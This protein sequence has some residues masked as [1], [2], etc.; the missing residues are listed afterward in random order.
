MKI[1]I[2][3]II[4]GIIIL[5]LSNNSCKEKFIDINKNII[6][7]TTIDNI[8]IK[9]YNLNFF[10][11]L[12]GDELINLFNKDNIIKVNIPLNKHANQ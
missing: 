1:I 11:S 6:T 10:Y 5:I 3:A 9:S 4:I 2:L 8:L 7:F 12:Y